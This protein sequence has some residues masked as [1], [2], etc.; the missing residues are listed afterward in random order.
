MWAVVQRQPVLSRLWKEA[1]GHHGDRAPGPQ[2]GNAGEGEQ[3]APAAGPDAGGGV[4]V[5]L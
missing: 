3:G 1:V 4:A 5:R 2:W